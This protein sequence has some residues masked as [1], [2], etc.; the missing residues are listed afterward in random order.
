MSIVYK[1]DTVLTQFSRSVLDT[2]KYYSK[3]ELLFIEDQ[4]SSIDPSTFEGRSVSFFTTS[5]SMAE[6]RAKFP[7][8]KILILANQV[9]PADNV[10]FFESTDKL[11][12]KLT[13]QTVE[14]YKKRQEYYQGLGNEKMVKLFSYKIKRI[15]E[16]FTVFGDRL[17]RKRK[18]F[19]DNLDTDPVVFWLK[20]STDKTSTCEKVREFLKD[21]L[22]TIFEYSDPEKCIADIISNENKCIFVM[23]ARTYPADVKN[24]LKNHQNVF[25][26]HNF[27]PPQNTVEGEKTM[28]QQIIQ[29]LVGDLINHYEAASKFYQSKRRKEQHNE[30]LKKARNACLFMSESVI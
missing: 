3:D 16:D 30:T 13:D 28:R 26:L 21:H 9:Y 27:W 23:V 5:D 6:I 29:P 10:L 19:N 1:L 14:N 2:L 4:L 17:L 22:P 25:H 12:A 20:S 15:H 8:L 18:C 7:G 24:R 11:I